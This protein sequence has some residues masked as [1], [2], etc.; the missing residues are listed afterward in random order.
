MPYFQITAKTIESEKA[1]KLDA[2]VVS[3]KDNAFQVVLLLKSL[4]KV[5]P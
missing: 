4:A 2:C 3:N 5:I 1:R